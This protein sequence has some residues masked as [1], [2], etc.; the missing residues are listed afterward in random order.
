[1]G[2][3]QGYMLYNSNTAWGTSHNQCTLRVFALTPVGLNTPLGPKA[4]VA[5]VLAITWRVF[6]SGSP[7]TTHHARLLRH[8]KPQVRSSEEL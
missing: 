8:R 5:E 2:T 6:K 4:L 3:P 1:M 7:A